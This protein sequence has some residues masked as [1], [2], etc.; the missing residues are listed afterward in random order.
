MPGSASSF[1]F[2]PESTRNAGT[3]VEAARMV[4]VP[5]ILT[6]AWAVRVGLTADATS[7]GRAVKVAS[8]D[9]EGIGIAWRIVSSVP[10]GVGMARDEDCS[11]R[12]DSISSIS[13]GRVV[14]CGGDLGGCPSH[15]PFM[16]AS[17]C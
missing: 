9:I 11:V 17:N 10:T 16:I 3:V 12:D 8:V 15:V 6:S 13:V 14:G 1:I 5:L 7:S 4:L 2:A